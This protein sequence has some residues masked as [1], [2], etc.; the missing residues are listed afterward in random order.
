MPGRLDS[1]LGEAGWEG[2][3]RP[4]HK[5][6]HSGYSSMSLGEESYFAELAE[7]GLY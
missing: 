1:L 6:E 5:T 3:G 4:H 2:A 7:E